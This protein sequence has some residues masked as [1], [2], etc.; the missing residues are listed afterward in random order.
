MG[1][2]RPKEA[3]VALRL[4]RATGHEALVASE[5]VRCPRAL[6]IPSLGIEYRDEDLRIR[7]PT[8]PRQLPHCYPRRT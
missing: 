7:W 8:A 5:V 4:T 6:A 3:T 2:V 1:I